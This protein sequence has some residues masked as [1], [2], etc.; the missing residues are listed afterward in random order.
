MGWQ[1]GLTTFIHGGD[2]TPRPQAASLR[3]AAHRERLLL[4]ALITALFDFEGHAGPWPPVRITD[5]L[6]LA[7]GERPL[8][9]T[10]LSTDLQCLSVRG[11]ASVLG[12]SRHRLLSEG[13]A[14]FD[15]ELEAAT[16][17]FFE[18]LSPA[19]QADLLGAY[20]RGELGVSLADAERFLDCL[21]ATIT[22]AFLC[23]DLV[24]AAAGDP[25]SFPS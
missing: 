11:G 24:P 25:A 17:A 16:G 23:V 10:D 13:M 7:Q 22:R 3:I 20:E 19:L 8:Y 2:V 14:R 12:S 18:E 9:R 1:A 15:A 21:V 5:L 6:L 4:P